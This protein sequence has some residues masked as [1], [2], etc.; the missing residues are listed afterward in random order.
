MQ[1][2]SYDICANKS[3][4]SANSNNFISNAINEYIGEAGNN[5]LRVNATAKLDCSQWYKL[6]CTLISSRRVIIILINF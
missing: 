4:F 3:N 2:L 5:P 6:N 1:K